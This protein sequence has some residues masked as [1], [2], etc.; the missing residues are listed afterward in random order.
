MTVTDRRGSPPFFNFA[1]ETDRCQAFHMT[2]CQ[3]MPLGLVLLSLG[4]FGE[5]N[6]LCTQFVKTCIAV[7]ALFGLTDHDPVMGATHELCISN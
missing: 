5:V 1:R 6:Q 3:D 4:Y 2:R 7:Y